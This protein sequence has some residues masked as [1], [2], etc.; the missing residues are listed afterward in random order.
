MTVVY[1]T[2][3]ELT[4]YKSVW[5]P[6][7]CC[8]CDPIQP[9]THWVTLLSL[10]YFNKVDVQIRFEVEEPCILASWR[11]VG[12]TDFNTAFFQ[13]SHLCKHFSMPDKMIPPHLLVCIVL[14]V[15]TSSPPQ[16][17]LENP[18]ENQGEKKG[19]LHWTHRVLV[20]AFHWQGSLDES[21]P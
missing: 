4:V 2:I 21:H 1:N 20:Q 12:K 14:G 10:T 5:E 19:K 13:L 11:K 18:G 8:G 3:L 15:L 6:V 9:W 7:W 17:V 16:W